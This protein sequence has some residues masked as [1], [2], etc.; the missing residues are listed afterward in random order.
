ML[1]PGWTASFAPC[2]VGRC[3]ISIQLRTIFGRA[4]FF[5]AP[6]QF[7]LGLRPADVKL[8]NPDYVI[9]KALQSLPPRPHRINT[10][11]PTVTELGKVSR[12]A[13]A[14]RQTAALGTKTRLPAQPCEK[15]E[16]RGIS[17]CR[18]A[19]PIMNDWQCLEWTPLKW[20]DRQFARNCS[21]TEL[22]TDPLASDRAKEVDSDGRFATKKT[23]LRP[24]FTPWQRST[25][26]FRF[27]VDSV[28]IDAPAR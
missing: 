23:G 16:S 22:R 3:Q 28:E 17:L 26:E 24:D 19:K 4:A 27:A 11:F 13:T 5:V 10:R 9:N 1:P 25:L 12:Y 21:W 18:L 7:Q 8:G 15:P 2:Y 14:R 20:P 6:C